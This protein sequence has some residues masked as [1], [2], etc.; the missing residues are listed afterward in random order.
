MFTFY[1]WLHFLK[2][3]LVFQQKLASDK[4]FVLKLYQTLLVEIEKKNNMRLMKETSKNLNTFMISYVRRYE[5]VQ[6]T[7]EAI[8]LLLNKPVIETF[9]KI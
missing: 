3:N 9:I 5:F 8:T 2:I 6:F 1:V 7:L 4:K